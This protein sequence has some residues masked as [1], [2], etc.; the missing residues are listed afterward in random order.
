MIAP[1]SRSSVIRPDRGRGPPARRSASDR[2]LGKPQPHQQELVGAL[3]AVEAVVGDDAVAVGLDPHQPGFRPLLGGDGVADAV[4]VETTV[5]AG[6]NAGICVAAPVDQ[7]MPALGA[8][9]G[10]VGNL[11][12]RQAV[13]GADLLRHVVE[14]ARRRLVWGLQLAGGVQAE[15]RVPS[16]MVSDRA[17]GVRPLSDGECQFAGP[18]LRRLVGR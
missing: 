5:R 4:D 15:E 13:A 18:V 14:D 10:V 8:G 17:K 11:V 7:V 2:C 9:A 6:T 3:L 16:S 1:S 12:G